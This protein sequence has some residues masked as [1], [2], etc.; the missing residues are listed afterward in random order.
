MATKKP[1]PRRKASAKTPPKVANQAAKKAAP[2]KKPAK[3]KTVKPRKAI[4]KPTPPPEI[5]QQPPDKKSYKKWLLLGL[6]TSLIIVTALLGGFYFIN[7]SRILPPPRYALAQIQNDL[8]FYY[9][10]RLPKGFTINPSTIGGQADVTVY[11]ISYGD[12]KNLAVSIQAIPKD[13]DFGN[14]YTHVMRG[15]REV[16]SSVGQAFMGTIEDRSV[17]SIKGQ[18]AWIL[19]SA[20][21][22]INPSELEE[23]V[24]HLKQVQR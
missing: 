23:V 4:V 11:A 9:P 22:G 2:K 3:A 10:Y 19:I 13:F 7:R 20:P 5:P 8:P 15:T 21:D 24:A 12:N 14:F 17:V 6:A 18:K 1:S 16:T